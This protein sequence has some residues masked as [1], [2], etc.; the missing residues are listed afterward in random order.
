MVIALPLLAQDDQDQD[1]MPDNWEQQVGLDATNPADAFG[2]ADGD[3]I[4]NLQEYILD[5]DPSE[6]EAS[7][8]YEYDPSL[9]LIQLYQYIKNNNTALVR[10]PQGNYAF[11]LG[12]FWNKN[13]R[14][15]LQ[16]GWN[17]DFTEYDPCKYK[18]VLSSN[19]GFVLSMGGAT[20]YSGMVL[21]GIEFIGD[22]TQI[23]PVTLISDAHPADYHIHNCTFRGDRWGINISARFQDQ[24]ANITF[25]NTVIYG[26]GSGGIVLAGDNATTFDIRLINCTLHN[27][28]ASNGGITF[29]RFDATNEVDVYL[30][31]SIL[32]ENGDRGAF[33]QIPSFLDNVSILTER[34]V[35]KNNSTDF[36]ITTIES[37]LDSPTYIDAAGGNFELID[38]SPLIDSGTLVGLPYTG[39]AIDIGAI[40]KERCP[41]CRLNLIC[42]ATPVSNST[43]SDG[44]ATVDVENGMP[45]YSYAWSNGAMENRLLN[46]AIGDYQ[47]T[48][49]DANGCTATCNVVVPDAPEIEEEFPPNN[50]EVDSLDMDRDGMDNVWEIEVG[51]DPNDPTD[52]LG[53]SD[54]D[55][56]LN[57]F[58]YMLG[59]DPFDASSPEKI[60]FLPT[61]SLEEY[62]ELILR[63]QEETILVQLIEGEY[64]NIYFEDAQNWGG[65]TPSGWR[66]DTNK[67]IMIQGGWKSDLS[68]YNPFCYT[69]QITF[70][71]YFFV[72]AKNQADSMIFILDGLSIKEHDDWKEEEVTGVS[73]AHQLGFLFW[74]KN[75]AAGVVKY[76]LNN[77]SII[78]NRNVFTFNLDAGAGPFDMYI[79]NSTLANNRHHFDLR[80]FNHQP[81]VRISIINSTIFDAFGDSGLFRGFFELYKVSE[82]PFNLRIINSIFMDPQYD[83][84]LKILPNKNVK[85]EVYNSV[86]SDGNAGEFTSYRQEGVIR[87][88]PELTIDGHHF[89]LPMSSPLKGAGRMTGIPYDISQPG[90]D[91]GVNPW[92]LRLDEPI[93]ENTNCAANDGYFVAQACY[94]GAIEYS[95][96]QLNWS[97]EPLFDNLAAGD[98][99][100]TARSLECDEVLSMPVEIKN[101][102][103]DIAV[104][105]MADNGIL[106]T[107]ASGG[108]LPYTYAWNTSIQNDTDFI[109]LGNQEVYMVTITDAIGCASSC[110]YVL[111]NTCENPILLN[112]PEPLSASCGLA[113]GKITIVQSFDSTTTFSLDGELYSHT[114]VF[115]N[116]EA[117]N[118][119]LYAKDA[120]CSDSVSF[121]IADLSAPILSIDTITSA[122]CTAN[123]GTVQLKAVGSLGVSNFIYHVNGESNSTGLFTGLAAG[124]YE[125]IVQDFIGCEDTLSFEIVLETGLAFNKNGTQVTPT[126]CGLENGSVTLQL[127]GQGDVYEVF[128]NQEQVALVNEQLPA[129]SYQFRLEDTNGCTDTVLVEIPAS[130][131]V[132]IIDY[133][134]TATSCAESNGKIMLSNLQGNPTQFSLNGDVFS[135]STLYENLSAGDYEIIATDTQC[136]DTISVNIAESTKPELAVFSFDGT[137]CGEDNGAV[138]LNAT[139]GSGPYEYNLET[140]NSSNGIFTNLS[141]GAYTAYVEDLLTCLDSTAVGIAD[142]EKA[143]LMA[144]VTD[145]TC[146][147]LGSVR[148]S[149]VGGGGSYEYALEEND[150]FT[151]AELNNLASGTYTFYLRTNDR[152]LDTLSLRVNNYLKP[153]IE[154]IDSAP[155]ACETPS[156]R[157][158]VALTQGYGALELKWEEEEFGNQ[159][160]FTD[161]A[162]GTYTLTA[163]DETDCQITLQH[164]VIGTPPIQ[165]T[166]VADRYIICE[167]SKPQLNFVIEGGTGK[168]DTLLLHS[169]GDTVSIQQPLRTGPYILRL[170]DAVGCEAETSLLIQQDC[171]I[172]IPNVFVP[173]S[174]PP[175][176]K[177][178]VFVESGSNLEIL[179]FK[180]FDRWGALLY[181][182]QNIDPFTFTDWWDGTVHGQAVDTG[183]Y[184]YLIKYQENGKQGFISDA[185]TVLGGK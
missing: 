60:P 75:P 77:C 24:P 151:T 72:Y 111:E 35:V 88:L 167:T 129:G 6:N 155:A 161:L 120:S 36:Q 14:I 126:S 15:M 87:E 68:T 115:E 148:L 116:L 168:L 124:M 58:E 65:P 21:D 110:Q 47:V 30:K 119:V 179:E 181:D 182:Q 153:S 48:V 171:S 140:E 5:L 89:K 96:D 113:N 2:D 125:A 51:L 43:A 172:Y 1:G 170:T 149:A 8:I 108:V 104:T 98:Y 97:I 13:H 178:R 54:C 18:T 123:Y 99:T 26:C 132:E 138:E 12:E 134:L 84:S 38:G 86:F 118:Y 7:F 76:A 139:Q 146:G 165:L 69:T 70:D 56:V 183:V 105:C 156:G 131:G 78:D 63:S 122:A 94:P 22:Q 3:Q 23:A 117:G 169:S 37:I 34:S 150:F 164:E 83:N 102:D 154:I 135:D 163:K 152:C 32:W 19:N 100:L 67:K 81:D 85:L 57:L 93:I 136:A 101:L 106:R 50:S 66:N 162:S 11:M 53:D 158:S 95:I 64:D 25:S 55:A 46:L 9:P 52:A 127:T 173:T 82:D 141:A 114:L 71:E 4:L 174:F 33:H 49:S 45:L 176:D 79:I 137:S 20:D 61:Q 17:D 80:M 107:E 29:N 10:I 74:S 175:N 103:S 90:P 128:L 159:L 112:K 177:L 144:T 130:E 91:I 109:T 28:N 147:E 145:G 59:S 73:T 16:G 142:S 133:Q 44:T 143:S 39:T 184:V 185:V 27:P 92:V 180:I 160:D 41:D 40:E 31:N 62:Q 157:L 42:A 166:E 121:L